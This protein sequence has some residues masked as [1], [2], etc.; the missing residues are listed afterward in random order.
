[1]RMSRSA[2]LENF[3]LRWS[4]WMML[5]ELFHYRLQY[6]IMLVRLVWLWL[7][8]VTI[9]LNFPVQRHF[10]RMPIFAAK[11]LRQS[12]LDFS[13][14]NIKSDLT[15]TTTLYHVY[16]CAKWCSH[17][18]LLHFMNSVNVCSVIW[19]I[20]W[21]CC[22]AETPEGEVFVRSFVSHYPEG[23]STPYFFCS[24]SPGCSSVIALLPSPP[25][26]LKY[27]I[28]IDYGALRTCLCV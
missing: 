2:V 12:G 3:T 8:F 22:G 25:S 28:G 5:V 6:E 27:T 17:K 21:L 9:S 18:A 1:M 14:S 13:S 19:L 4:L 20:M 24:E 26:Q 16:F 11:C 15:H 23:F 7:V 10:E